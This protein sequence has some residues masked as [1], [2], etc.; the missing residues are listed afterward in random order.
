[1]FTLFL[2]KLI[3]LL[4][5]YSKLCQNCSAGGEFHFKSPINKS[6]I[7]TSARISGKLIKLYDCGSLKI[8][9]NS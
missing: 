8:N 7:G 2:Y 4:N 9:Y 1:M 6:E 5:K 3:L